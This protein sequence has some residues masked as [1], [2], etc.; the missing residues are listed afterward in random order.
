MKKLFNLVHA[1]ARKNAAACCY[2]SPDDWC[3]EF[4]PRTRSLDQN[5][6]L[7]GF[8]TDISNQVVWHGKTLDPESWKHIFSSSLKKQTVVPNLEGDG[9]VVMGISTSKMSKQEMSELLELI[10]AFGAQH[11]VKF[12]DKGF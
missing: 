12:S 8:L 3:V 1:E 11:G 10:Q 6:A 9:F 2:T 5:A 7:W 4:K